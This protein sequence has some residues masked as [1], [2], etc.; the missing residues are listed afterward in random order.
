MKTFEVFLSFLFLL[1]SGCSNKK[2]D[3][4][5]WKD[6]SINQPVD[7]KSLSMV[8]EVVGFAGG[9]PLLESVER[10]Q[11][12]NGTPGVYSDDNLVLDMDTS[13]IRME[14][15]AKALCN[16][17]YKTIDGGIT[18]KGIET[19]FTSGI[20]CVDFVDELNG[21]VVT[22]EEGAY[23]TTD[24]GSTWHQMLSN[25]F[26]LYKNKQVLNCI[27]KVTFIDNYRGFAYSTD[28]EY[29]VLK[30]MN[31]G[32][33]WECLN[34]VY[35]P[36]IPAIEPTL[37]GHGVDAIVFTSTDT[38]YV[39]SQRG[40]KLFQTTDGGESWSQI[41]G[42]QELGGTV[43]FNGA[44]IYY[45]AKGLF[46]ADKGNQWSKTLFQ[47][48]ITTGYLTAG[49]QLYYY[50]NMAKPSFY[51][52]NLNDWTGVSL[53]AEINTYVTFNDMVITTSGVGIAVGDKGTVLRYLE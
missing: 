47:K 32:L 9:I 19:S 5:D 52:S 28:E 40:V 4:Y 42:S 37:F 8:N 51:K 21:F 11:I 6:A 22:N 34:L 13:E 45:P 20:V 44:C 26:H 41:A 29:L 18:W 27:N 38:G 30:T 31:G 36:G 49:N 23:R 53:S 16:S 43:F 14:F 12:T 10:V 1:V 2:Q 15:Y 25:F 17:L 7:L 48:S 3:L 24:G 50:E 46:S 39:S 33:S 35:P